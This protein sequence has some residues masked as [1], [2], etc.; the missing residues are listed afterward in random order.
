MSKP[1]KLISIILVLF[2][3]TA[4]GISLDGGNLKI[5]DNGN[6]IV[7]IG[8]DGFKLDGNLTGLTLD[9]NG[10]RIEYPNGSLIWGGEGLDVKHASGTIRIA[11]GRMVVTD[12]D[13]KQRIL[14]TKGDGAEYS[15][16][17]GVQVRTGQKA[18]L[19]EDYPADELPLMDGFE[20]SASALLGS[21]EVISGYVPG[22][23]V[24]EVS[25]YYQP[26][27]V[28]SDNYSQ[29][30]KD[31]RV[32]LTASLGGREITVYLFKSLTTDA[33]NVSIVIGKT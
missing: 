13:G 29:K 11:D 12:K 15:T 10:L 28:K 26:L 18:A 4:C 27:M 24:E 16:D 20:L 8:K 17:G 30:I 7:S 33:V 23:T 21:I 1:I 5:Q 22:K 31:S 3:L 9:G 6:D 32:V 25:A 19:P 14:D 2:L